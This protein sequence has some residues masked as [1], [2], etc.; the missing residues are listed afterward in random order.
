MATNPYAKIRYYA[1]NMVPHVHINA[2]YLLE[3]KALSYLG[4]HLYLSAITQNPDKSPLPTNPAPPNNVAIKNNITLMKMVL[5]STA[6][7]EFGAV[8][9]NMVDAVPICKNP[10]GNGGTKVKINAV[11]NLW[12]FDGCICFLDLWWVS[13]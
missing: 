11:S 1:S 2:S 12:V 3:S 4:G 7:A 8:S 10:G 5:A 6:E 9:F 13:W